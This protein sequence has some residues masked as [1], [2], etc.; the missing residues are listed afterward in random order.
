MVA[1]IGELLTEREAG[2]TEEVCFQ[3][4]KAIAGEWVRR[5]ELVV[6]G[7]KGKWVVWWWEGGVN[8]WCG[9]G[10]GGKWVVWWWEKG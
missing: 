7:G 2:K 4:L 6:G 3:Q 5:G 8:G 10:R 9:G 1:C